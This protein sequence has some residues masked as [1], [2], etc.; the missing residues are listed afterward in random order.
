M[1]LEY[2]T[3]TEYGVTF[4]RLTHDEDYYAVGHDP[5][6]RNEEGELIEG[7][8]SWRQIIQMSPR[9]DKPQP[10]NSKT[11]SLFEGFGGTDWVEINLKIEEEGL[12]LPEEINKLKN[13]GF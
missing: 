6:P 4:N 5:Q 11:E 10:A 8:G 12:I 7:D 1:I 9:E 13:A 3:H 2:T